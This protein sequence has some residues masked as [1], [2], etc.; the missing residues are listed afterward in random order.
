MATRAEKDWNE[1]ADA[2]I[3]AKANEIMTDKKKTQECY[4]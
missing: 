4:C 1:R 3:L 2:R